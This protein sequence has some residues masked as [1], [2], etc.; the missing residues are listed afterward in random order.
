MET[1]L[2]PTHFVARKLVTAFLDGSYPAGASLPGERELARTLG[3]TRPTLR[4]TLQRLDREGWVTIRH[5]KATRVND[6]WKEGGMGLLATLAQHLSFLPNGFLDHLMA[7]RKHILPGIVHLAALNA[8]EELLGYLEKTPLLE[9]DPRTYVDYDWGLQILQARC[10]RNPIYPLIMNDFEPM[11]KRLA[12]HYFANQ[13]ARKAS[14][15]Y[16]ELLLK[17]IAENRMDG[18]E[19]LVQHTMDDSIHIWK[20]LQERKAEEA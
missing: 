17:A 15:N 7:F 11:F 6:F 2:R 5:G 13:K 4:E 20:Q 9:A 19:G 18:I 10:S 14:R 16:Y 8:P 12:W 3:V 1:P